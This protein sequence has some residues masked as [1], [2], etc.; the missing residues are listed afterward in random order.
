MVALLRFQPV[1][2]IFSG[3]LILGQFHNVLSQ[4]LIAILKITVH[5]IDEVNYFRR[6]ISAEH[7]LLESCLEV[8]LIVAVDVFRL[9]S[10][11]HSCTPHYRYIS[12]YP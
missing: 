5:G 7:F 2:L 12:S 4:I 1:Q 6:V 9:F 10:M 8:I 11:F 3:L